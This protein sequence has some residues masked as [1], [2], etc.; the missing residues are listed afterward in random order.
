VGS[1]EWQL[2]RLSLSLSEVSLE[3]SIAATPSVVGV[4]SSTNDELSGSSDFKSTV[5]YKFSGIASPRQIL[6]MQSKLG[7]TSSESSP[8]WRAAL[9]AS[10]GARSATAGQSCY[11]TVERGEVIRTRRSY[12]ERLSRAPIRTL[13]TPPRPIYR[14]KALIEA[15]ILVTITHFRHKVAWP[16][17][18]APRS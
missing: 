16:P 1:S 11:V 12:S 7:T 4:V 3:I 17:R 5:V 18:I 9:S 8:R 13:S 6:M 2:A 15:D 10:T 14:W